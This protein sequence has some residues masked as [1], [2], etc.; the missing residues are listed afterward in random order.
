MYLLNK[1]FFIKI[2]N[3]KNYCYVKKGLVMLHT[4][5]LRLIRT[6]LYYVLIHNY[7]F[8]RDISDIIFIIT[9]LR[10]VNQISN[11]LKTLKIKWQVESLKQHGMCR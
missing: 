5:T 10:R 6:T 3:Y 1:I 2:K 7:I 11:V 4:M 8:M 9:F